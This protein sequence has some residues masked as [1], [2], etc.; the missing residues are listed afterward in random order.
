MVSLHLRLALRQLFI[1]LFFASISIPK[2]AIAWY[3][4]ACTEALLMIS[5]GAAIDNIQN[6]W[7]KIY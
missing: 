4:G 6:A 3:T 1:T 5:P 2:P 7:N